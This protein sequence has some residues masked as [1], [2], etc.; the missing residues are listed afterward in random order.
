MAFQVNLTTDAEA[1]LA[2]LKVHEQRIVL[3]GIGAHL[4][5][6]ADE[7][8]DR[9]KRL[10]P[11]PLAPWELRIGKYR[12]FYD[13]EGGATVWVTAIGWKEHNELFIRGKRVAL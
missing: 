11:N 2:Y 12:V 3:D 7:E 9:H 5:L 4:R 13:V 1:D 10:R 8:S 6:Q